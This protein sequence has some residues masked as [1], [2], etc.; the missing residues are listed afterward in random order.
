MIDTSVA[1]RYA[2]ALFDIATEKVQTTKYQ[3]ELQVLIDS[4]ETNKDFS[5]LLLG[6]VIT[7]S[8]K[9]ELVKKIFGNEFSQDIINFVC[10]VLDK[11][12]E[13]LLP[14][15]LT[16]YTEL[17]DAAAGVVPVSVTAAFEL[18]S[19]QLAAL[20]EAFTKKLGQPVRLDVSVD[21][22]LIGG[23]KAQVGDTVYDG[24]LVGRLADLGRQL[25]K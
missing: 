24:S 16:A 7:T 14:E 12:R 6:R 1:R 17:L 9:K 15:M 21:K 23:L 22:S 5:T 20:S 8:E 10:L 13:N 11:G 3:S 4:L 18:S 19:E 2:K 25:C